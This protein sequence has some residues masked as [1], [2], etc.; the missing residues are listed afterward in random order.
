MAQLKR[1]AVKVAKRREPAKR[2]SRVTLKSIQSH[3]VGMEA[4]TQA[5]FTLLDGKIDQLAS[6]MTKGF[7]AT[8][9][10]IEESD[11]RNEERFNE[12]DAK[13][14]LDSM[15]IKGLEVAVG[16][17]QSDVKV[18]KADVKEL[19]FDVAE[20]KLAVA[21][22]SRDIEQNSKDIQDLKVSIDEVRD[23]LQLDEPE[24]VIAS[25]QR[26]VTTP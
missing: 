20:L 14:N 13:L 18:L 7:E 2:K 9:Q 22:N 4:R 26:R 6:A 23:V 12:I 1:N 17:L 3:M 16:D 10:H 15:A 21:K 5:T 8:W 19:K 24:N 25:L 11:R